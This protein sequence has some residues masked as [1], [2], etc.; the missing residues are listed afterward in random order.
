MHAM[1]EQ[2]P[3]FRSRRWQ[4]AWTVALMG[5][6]TAGCAADPSGPVPPARSPD[7]T[8]TILAAIDDVS[9]RTR[10]KPG[11]VKLDS[12]ESV[13]WQDGSL[14]CP[15]PDVMYTQMLVPGYRVRIE[16]GGR[17]W[18][19]HAAKFGTPMLCLDEK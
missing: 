16:A 9:C 17:L 5:A 8:R 19:Y 3:P 12:A 14:G 15:E 10:L 13:T 11:A 2:T 18:V 1:D 4:S 6:V 7:L